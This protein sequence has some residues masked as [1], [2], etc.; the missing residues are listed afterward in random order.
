MQREEARR[1]V[2]FAGGGGGVVWRPV[3]ALADRIAVGSL[4]LR[5]PDGTQHLAQG[6]QPGPAAEIEVR[7]TRLLRRLVLGGSV[8]MGEAY[9][10]GDW[11]SPDIA[12]LVELAARNGSAALGP[13]RRWAPLRLAHRALHRLRP[14]SRAGSRRNIAAHYDLG[15][16][17][18]AAWLDAGMTYSAAMPA[19]PDEPLETAQDRKY[20]AIAAAAGL[21][22]GMTVLEIG[23]GWGGFAEIAARDY[24][25]RVTGLTLSREQCAYAN[26]RAADAGL[27]DR[28]RHVLRDYRDETGVYDA[29]VSIEMIEAVGERYWP[30]FYAV[31]RDRL[32]PGGIAALQAIT[33]E[34]ARF[35]RYRRNADFIQRYVFPGGMLPTADAIRGGAA[36]AGLRL[37][38]VEA[39]GPAY[40][41]T[42]RRW[43]ERFDAAWPQIAAMGCDERFRRL[44]RYYLAYCE[45]GFRAGSLDV[46]HFRIVRP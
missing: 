44:W 14:N 18:F 32:R 27:G 19:A 46:G 3:R 38:E 43:R 36:V 25:C 40:A 8:A 2:A 22:P 29:A 12:A 30:Q 13:A 7:R 45:G 23:S 11:E 10:D 24:G 35:E 28:V 33:I 1:D 5:F 17:F 21:R 41:W 20:R 6:A 39:F 16:D 34:P 37:A 9:V 31:L 15:N 26:R 4:A 42:L